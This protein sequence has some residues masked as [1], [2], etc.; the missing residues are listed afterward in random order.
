M[1]CTYNIFTS[2][3]CNFELM[4]NSQYI[5]VYFVISGRAKMIMDERKAEYSA[6]D[7]FI[8]TPEMRVSH[9]QSIKGSIICLS[10]NKI[11]FNK[12]YLRISGKI[13]KTHEI[14]CGMKKAMLNYIRYVYEEDLLMADI[15]VI[16]LINYMHIYYSEFDSY[17]FNFTRNEIIVKAITHINNNY[18]A[19]LALR[20][21]AQ[22]LFVN[23]SFLSRKF[24][25]EMRMGFSE[26]V[27]RIKLYR[28]A[29]DL[30]V[31]GNEKELWKTYHFASYRTFLKNFKSQFNMTPTEFI[32]Q[33]KQCKIKEKTVTENIYKQAL[34]YLK[35]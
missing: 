19:P 2:T 9:I 26:Y 29:E 30:L 35:E 1:D 33:S 15:N 11:H 8:T 6:G 4:H 18:K 10:I 20:D 16:K 24:K 23:S 13:K 31:S 3:F 17:I 32:L 14:K 34:E 12:Y 22:C 5:T 27:R 25:A 28:F 7:I 21:V